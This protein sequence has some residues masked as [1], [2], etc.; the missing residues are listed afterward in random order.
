MRMYDVIA[1]KRDGGEL[2][3]DEIAF[4]IHGN[5]GLSGQRSGDGDLPARHDGP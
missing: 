1:K 5:S 4:F 3:R 2:S